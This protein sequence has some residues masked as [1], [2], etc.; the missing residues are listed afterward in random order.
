MDHPILD[1]I[2]KKYGKTNAQIMLRWTIDY[3]TVTLPKSTHKER[4]EENFDI[5]DFKLTNED[6]SEL[7]NLDEN[8][9]TAWD[10]TNVT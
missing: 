2:A 1:K 7:A 9:R 4:I 3:G 6:M 10:P 5:F 8:L